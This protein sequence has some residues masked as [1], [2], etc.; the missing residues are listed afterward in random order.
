MITTTFLLLLISFELFYLTSK[1]FK[2][3]N[4]PAYLAKIATNGKTYRLVAAALFVVATILFIIS[5]GWSSGLVAIIVGIMAAGSLIV[6]LQP[7]RYLRP[8]TIAVLYFSILIL[9]FLI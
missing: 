2:E 3:K 6:L 9:E 5:L 8:T 1:Q 4:T 7:F